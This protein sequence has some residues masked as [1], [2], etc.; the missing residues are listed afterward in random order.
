M[1]IVTISASQTISYE[2]LKSYHVTAQAIY[3]AR[4]RENHSPVQEYEYELY[5]KAHSIEDGKQIFMDYLH[6]LNDLHVAQH[7][8]FLAYITQH[9]VK[10]EGNYV[11]EEASVNDFLH[12]ELEVLF[13]LLTIADKKNY[14]TL[15][16]EVSSRSISNS[17]FSGYLNILNPDVIKATI[18]SAI[19]AQFQS[20]KDN[21]HLYS[22]GINE[23]LYGIEQ[24]TLSN[25]NQL[26]THVAPVTTKAF[27]AQLLYTVAVTLLKFLNEWSVLNP[28]KVAMTND[29]LRVIYRTCKLHNLL[30]VEHDGHDLSEVNYMRSVLTN[31][32]YESMLMISTDDN[33]N[34]LNISDIN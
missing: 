5:I 32:S 26:L 21:I 34:L 15:N 30:E 11:S 3:D 28:N 19:E 31:K 29:Q 20:I 17:D 16:L 7:A 2:I 9:I 24:P 6:K 10:F 18:L 22:L 27:K 12:G 14:K 8:G 4:I 25:I 1:N 13:K 23:S 33:P